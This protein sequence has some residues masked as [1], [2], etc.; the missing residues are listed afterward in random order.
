V[1]PSGAAA[2]YGLGLT[3]QVPIRA[4]YLTSGASQRL[5]LGSQTVELQKAPAWKLWGA[6]T[7]EGDVLRALEWIGRGVV[8]HEAAKLAIKNLEPEQRQ[9]LLLACASAPSWLSKIITGALFPSEAER[10]TMGDA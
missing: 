6:G 5:K 3:K 10:A 8:T 9:R 7:Q 4:V 2:A 1:V